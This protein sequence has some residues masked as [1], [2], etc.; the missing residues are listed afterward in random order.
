[1]EET[2]I[3][4]LNYNGKQHLAEFLPSVILHTKA[5]RVVVVDN[6]SSDDSVEFLRENFSTVELLLSNENRGFAGGYNWALNQIQAKY[7]I[8]LNS[9]VEVSSNWVAPLVQVLESS[10]NIAACQ[11]KILNYHNKRYFEYAGAAGGFLDKYGYPFCRGRIFD[12][13]EQDNGQYDD[14]REIFWASGAC[15]GIKAEDFH[16]VGG[17]DADFFAHM[18]EIDLC[19]RIKQTGKQIY[20]TSESTV[21]HLG[22]GTLPKSNPKKTFLNFRNSLLM[23]LKNLPNEKVF[24]VIFLRMALDGIAAIRGLIQ[25]NVADFKAI[26]NAHIAFYQMLPKTRKKRKD[27][28]S[29]AGFYEKSIVKTYFSDKIKFFGKL[30]STNFR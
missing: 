10:P 23:L 20:Y 22:G 18:E 24:P 14:T 27:T 21:F 1:M 13:I 7:Y 2:A 25:G 28:I 3:V 16:T 8:L 30:K 11:P 19:W 29:V 6:G 4:I 17:F 26:F 15:L 5:Y 12:T 9:D